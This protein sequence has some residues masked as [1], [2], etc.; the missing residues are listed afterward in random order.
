MREIKFRIWDKN[1]ESWVE[2]KCNPCHSDGWYICALSGKL[3]SPSDGDECCS[4]E[5]IDSNY[6]V[7]QFTGCRDKNGQ[8][9][10]EGD[11]LFYVAKFSA[12]KRKEGRGEIFWTDGCFFLGRELEIPIWSIDPRAIEVVGNII[13]HPDM[14]LAPSDQEDKEEESDQ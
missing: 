2:D 5:L 12:V 14:V 10:C 9:I 7:Q 6:T 4:A 1:N 3:K 11:I 8:E 13:E